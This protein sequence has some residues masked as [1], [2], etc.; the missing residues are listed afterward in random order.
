ML[1]WYI[2]NVGA[3]NEWFG[4]LAGWLCSVLVALI[5]ADVLAKSLFNYSNVAIFEAEWHIFSL[6]FL[7]GAA[8][9]LKHDRHVRV[10]LFYSKMSKKGKAWIDLIGVLVFLLPFSI[11]VIDKS[12][13]YTKTSFLMHESSPDPG[14]LPARFML[15]G[16]IIVS[17]VLLILQ[18]ISMAFEAL[19]IILK[20]QE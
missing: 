6:I 3:L 16:L 11:L 17:F 12:L 9:T 8:Y 19:M 13:L 2:K 7:L 20:K 15:K 4:K 14:G 18:G 5:C 1:H 10:D